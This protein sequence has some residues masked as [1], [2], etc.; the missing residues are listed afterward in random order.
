M[1]WI[2]VECLNQWRRASKKE[3]RYIVVDVAWSDHSF[4]RCDECRHEYSFRIN[5][6]YLLTTRRISPCEIQLT[7][8]RSNS[9]DSDDI[10]RHRIHFWRPYQISAVSHKDPNLDSP[11]NNFSPGCLACCSNCPIRSKVYP[12]CVQLHGSCTLDFW[13]YDPR[14]RR[15]YSNVTCRRDG[16]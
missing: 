15:V 16:L 8:S 5:S 3:S 7:C 10:H 11:A 2:H 13:P 6:A 4:F 12:G 14:T 9:S 1:K